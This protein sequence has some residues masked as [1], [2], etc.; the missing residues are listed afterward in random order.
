MT[1][2]KSTILS[3]MNSGIYSVLNTE[4]RNS[5]IRVA[6]FTAIIQESHLR[7]NQA[8]GRTVDQQGQKAFK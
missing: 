1:V 3:F 6:L 4:L 5:E 7:R 8:Y 2:V